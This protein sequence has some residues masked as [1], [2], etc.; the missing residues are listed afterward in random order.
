[1][2]AG[3][4]RS[5]A[6]ATGAPSYT[7]AAAANFAT[8][9]TAA[10]SCASAHEVVRRGAHH[11]GQ[12]A[13]GH[14]VERR[15]PSRDAHRDVLPR[16]RLLHLRLVEAV[17]GERDQAALARAEIAHR[18]AGN[19]G[20]RGTQ[21]PATLRDLLLD[22]VQAEVQ[23]V[24]R[25]RDQAEATG[26][27]ALPELVHARV[28]AQR[29][30]VG[31]GPGAAL[32]IGELRPQDRFRPVAHHQEAGAARCAQPLAAGAGEDVDVQR[33]GVHGQLPDGLAGVQ[34]HQRVAPGVHGIA[35]PPHVGDDA[36]VGRHLHDRHQLHPLV[37][38]VGERGGGERAVGVAGHHLDRGA[39]RLR[40][41]QQ[42]DRVAAVL[43]LADQDAVA[44]AQR[45]RVQRGQPGAGRAVGEGDL[46]G[47]AAEQFGE[48]AVARLQVG[49][50]F[51]GS[52]IAADL[53]LAAQ[54][55]DHLVEDRSGHERTARA[56]Q[57]D[58]PR[59]PRGVRQ[60][61]GH[62]DHAW[63]II[64]RSRL[65][66]RSAPSRQSPDGSGRGRLT[67]SAAGILEP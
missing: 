20:Q 1:M 42:R 49:F 61:L 12:S 51:A 34:Q 37:E 9:P 25:G 57:E 15:G 33:L 17:D 4:P 46:V 32:Q 14:V 26:V 47:P 23:Q 59:R 6:S 43:D 28:V 60:D 40:P 44:G 56:V 29:V 58:P 50:A 24:A 52:L 65:T 22:R 66:G 54:V 41:H 16:E 5:P 8:A 39:D 2:R 27:V 31:A 45:H 19:L 38:H 35:D 48:H 55:A 64:R 36:A 62:V 13:P 10:S 30:A 11:L 53:G 7:P 18:D 63:E 21:V 67:R 3:R